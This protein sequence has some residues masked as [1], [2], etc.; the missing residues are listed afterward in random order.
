MA[1]P[2]KLSDSPTAMCTC[3]PTRGMSCPACDGTLAELAH[4]ELED[5]A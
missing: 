1:N 5:A 3:D 4:V 2:T